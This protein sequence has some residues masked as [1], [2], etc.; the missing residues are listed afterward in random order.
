MF[1]RLIEDV[2]SGEEKEEVEMVC[3][4]V[5]VGGCVVCTRKLS[6]HAAQH[7]LLFLSAENV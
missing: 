3:V 2:G 4:C 7:F 6:T 1:V 5:W